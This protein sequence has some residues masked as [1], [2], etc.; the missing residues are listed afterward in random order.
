MAFV[1]SAGCERRPLEEMD[2]GLYLNLNLNLNITNHPQPV[3]KPELMRVIF[4]DSESLEF[5]SDD[6]VLPEGGYISARPGKYKMVIYNFDTESTLVRGDSYAPQLEAYTN[7]I[8]S[9]TRTA[10]LTKLRAASKSGYMAPSAAER[11]VYEPDHLFV[12]REDVE[13]LHRTGTQTIHADASSIVETYYLGVKVQGGENLVSAQALLS[14]QSAGNNF[15]FEGGVS[16]QSVILYFDMKS[17]INDRYGSEVLQTTF[18]TFG[19]LPEE[20]SRLWLTIVAT[21][22]SGTTISWQQDITDLFKDNE[23]K[24]IYIEEDP[25]NP[26][27]I[28]DPPPTTQGG[29][30]Q[31][32][33]DD[34]D[35]IYEDI[36]L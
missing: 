16:Q 34:W 35:T 10:L 24:Y 22:V 8:P 1:L 23:D 26:L 15:A 3:S 30:F 11:I 5:I 32:E 31:P 18:N 29:G 13:I 28:P 7:D 33:V 4:Y 14:G 25:D 20:V 6:Y 9:T 19:K 36:L 27:I 17:G 12:A 21:N 2:D